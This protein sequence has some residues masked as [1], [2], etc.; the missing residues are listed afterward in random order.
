MKRHQSDIVRQLRAEE[1]RD[2]VEKVFYG[3]LALDREQISR[4]V[5]RWEAHH[6]GR[7]TPP[8]ILLVVPEAGQ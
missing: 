3:L 5:A 1:S 2:S 8:R 7:P 4:L 6:E